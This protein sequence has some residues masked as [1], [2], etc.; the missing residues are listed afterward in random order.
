MGLS[1]STYS[2]ES[3]NNLR[4]DMIDKCLK[5]LLNVLPE[6]LYVNIVFDTGTEKHL[7]LLKKYPFKIIEKNTNGG[8]AK[9]KNTG[10]KD[11]IDNNCDILF[12]SD[13]DILY[14]DGNIFKRYSDII[15][16]TNIH[17][18]SLWPFD[19][20]I[21]DKIIINDCELRKMFLVS[22]IFL[23]FTKE[24]INKIGYYSNFPYKYGHE[25][26]NFTLRCIESNFMPEPFYDIWN[27]N[28]SVKLIDENLTESMVINENDRTNNIAY[29]QSMIVDYEKVKENEKYKHCNMN[30]YVEFHE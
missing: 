6:N 2:N 25:H 7:E 11:L 9:C 10:I 30:I 29:P 28:E 20:D 3:T 5:S 26:T 27:S 1:I 8:I 14:K 16:K 19:S 17:H 22:G 13:D 15:E 12:L 21:N 24:V 4:Y 23:V 18:F